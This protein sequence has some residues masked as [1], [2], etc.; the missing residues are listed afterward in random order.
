MLDEK[1]HEEILSDA[2]ELR[3]IGDELIKASEKLTEKC[4]RIRRSVADESAE[5]LRDGKK[6]RENPS[7][8]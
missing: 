7:K 8:K 1:S 5:K 2:K 4:E 3:R 6:R